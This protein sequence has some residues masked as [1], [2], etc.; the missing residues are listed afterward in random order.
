M[1]VY[2]DYDESNSDKEENFE[3]A[4]ISADAGSQG[5][6]Q[7]SEVKSK[8]VKSKWIRTRTYAQPVNITGVKIYHVSRNNGIGLGG[9]VYDPTAQT[10]R[11]TAPSGAAGDVVKVTKDG[12]FQL[13]DADKTKY[14][15]VIVTTASLPGGSATDNISITALA[16]DTLAAALAQKLLSRYRDPA[17]S[18]S[19][20]VDINNAAYNSAF[21]KPTDLKDIT[22]DEASE[23]GV[24]TWNKER[25]MLTSVRPDFERGDEDVQ[26]LRIRGSRGLP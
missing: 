4:V 7:W 26:A 14:I 3:A 2:Y 13:F 22:T 10:L 9:L 11:W 17:A 16:G 12:K 24:T 6:S 25:V 20:E 1:V 23:K 5:A 8:V 19:F 15:R 21:V 18:V